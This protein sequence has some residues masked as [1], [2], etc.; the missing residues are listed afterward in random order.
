MN[1]EYKRRDP[2]L[3]E[4]SHLYEK[5]P[6]VFQML[7]SFT[8]EVGK[9]VANGMKNVTAEE[10]A[11]RLDTCMKCEFIQK[12]KMRCGKCG[13]LLEHKAKW[14]T[15]TCPDEPSRWEEQI[16]DG[17]EQENDNTTSGD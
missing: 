5:T 2:R 16:I 14:K 7:K 17:K 15:A 8:K 3:K 12:E 6:S 11:A 9:H 10:Y 4:N 13:C 1:K